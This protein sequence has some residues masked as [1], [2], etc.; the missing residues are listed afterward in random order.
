MSPSLRLRALSCLQQVLLLASARLAPDGPS[1]CLIA[2]LR[3][4]SS[5][6]NPA[7]AA[8]ALLFPRKENDRQ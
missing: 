6:C 8:P 7:T 5:S 1:M 3:A 4:D 2:Q